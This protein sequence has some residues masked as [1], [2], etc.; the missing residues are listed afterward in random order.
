M[1]VI[2]QDFNNFIHIGQRLCA[3]MF[4]VEFSEVLHNHSPNKL[5]FENHRNYEYVSQCKLCKNETNYLEI[6]MYRSQDKMVQKHPSQKD[7]KPI[8]SE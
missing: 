3:L 2:N 7:I 1:T 4:P 8:L 6:F 5:N